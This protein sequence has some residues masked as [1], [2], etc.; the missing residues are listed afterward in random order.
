MLPAAVREFLDT[1]RDRHLQEL[2]ELLRFAS[3]ANN[4]DD[5]CARCAAW[6]ADHLNAV[7]LTARVHPSAG[8]DVVLAESVA[9]P[10]KPTLLIYGHYDVQPPD[11]LDQW[12]SAPFEPVLRD[13]NIVARGADDDKGQLFT[14]LMAIDA[15]QGAGDL[16]VNV[17]VLI[18]GEEE[19]GSPSLESFV[20]EHKE[21]LSA[22]AAVISDSAFFA[23]G[24]PSILT[25]LRGLA[26][27]E[28][29]ARGPRV[30]VHSGVHGGLVANPINA[31]ARI[32]GAM[33][34]DTGSITV[35]GFYDD[36]VEPTEAER[37]SWNDLPFDEA[38]HAASVA[39]KELG[40][41]ERHLPAL[42][43]NWAQPTLDV[44]GIIGG[45]TDVGAKTIIPASAL[46]KIS[47]RLVAH[48]DPERIVDG[49]RQ[50]VHQHTPPGI[51]TEV[52]LHSTG[53]PVVLKTD[54]AAIQAAKSALAEAFERETVFIGCGASV[55]VTE[56]IQRL[57]GLDAA[58][59]GFGLPDDNLHSP[60]EKFALEQLTRGAVASAAFMAELAER[61]TSQ[62]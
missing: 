34:D 23:P 13:G 44:N 20:V 49:V 2:F 36:V 60:N 35:P 57:L 31:L 37:S 15:W 46:A 4:D 47:M 8:K 50:F 9:D 58:M 7:G 26:Y 14:H 43:R 29:E 33:H 48:Q 10:A 39:V 5:Q 22:D 52:R 27:V 11:P 24:I 42:V 51:E 25:G 16:P 12:L 18:E 1:H 17:K 40:G 32:I 41:G 38:D 28:I 21:A 45:Y 56:L 59:M 54:G 61:I 53:R 3:I 55:P 62:A 6:L 19:I 30:D